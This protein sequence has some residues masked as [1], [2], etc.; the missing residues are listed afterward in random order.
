MIGG[1]RENDGGLL[2]GVGILIS[3]AITYL[4]GKPQLALVA[5]L[6]FEQTVIVGIIPCLPLDPLKAAPAE[7]SNFPHDGSTI[8]RIQTY[9]A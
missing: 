5:N 3:R 7:K 6:N 9:F 4:C 8:E 2:A 1:D